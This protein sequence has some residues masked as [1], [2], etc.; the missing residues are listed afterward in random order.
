MTK[1]P[2]ILV[3]EDNPVNARLAEAL[4]A[5]QGCTAVVVE[6]GA[7]ALKAL[8]RIAFD[9][10]FMDM[11]M[12]VMDG[13]EATQVYRAAGGTLPIVALTANA[14][15]DDREACLNAGMNAFL[16]KP[17]SIADLKDVLA[18]FA[19]GAEHHAVA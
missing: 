15:D 1:A 4:L 12:P 3:A 17:I 19:G 13:V 7:E 8:D 18:R 9:L 2:H 14:F 5:S 16:S 11:R 6:N 10:V